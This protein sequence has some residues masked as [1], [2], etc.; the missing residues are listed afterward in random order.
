MTPAI[1]NWTITLEG[2]ADNLRVTSPGWMAAQSA[3]AG[4]V[5]KYMSERGFVRV[6]VRTADGVT[7]Y[8]YEHP[9]IELTSEDKEL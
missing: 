8:V 5:E 4:M 6:D 3:T 7:K 9:N 2:D 1:N